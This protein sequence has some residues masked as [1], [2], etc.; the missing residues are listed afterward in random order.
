MEY[1]IGIGVILGIIVCF[2]GAT[3]AVVAAIK[4]GGSFFRY[5]QSPPF[6]RYPLLRYVYVAVIVVVIDL[7]VFTSTLPESVNYYLIITYIILVPVCLSYPF[8]RAFL[9]GG[10]GSTEKKKST[11]ELL[12]EGID[13]YLSIGVSI[14][15]LLAMVVAIAM[16]LKMTFANHS[17]YEWIEEYIKPFA[18]FL[19]FSCFFGASVALLTGQP[20]LR[21]VYAAVI[22]FVI[23]LSVFTSFTSTLPE[24]VSFCFPFLFIMVVLASISAILFTV[25]PEAGDPLDFWD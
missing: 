16:A 15:T 14:T 11:I 6:F 1:I 10:E 20:L 19:Y 3:W 2:I 25:H 7:S 5:V 24:W 8:L 4:V 18:F 13:L 9:I 17:E 22:I 23:H 21:Y 12:I